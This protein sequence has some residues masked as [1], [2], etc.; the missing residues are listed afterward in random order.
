MAATLISPVRTDIFGTLSSIAG[1]QQKMITENQ[2]LKR[3]VVELEKALDVKRAK[4]SS[5]EA[6]IKSLM[7]RILSLSEKIQLKETENKMLRDRVQELTQNPKVTALEEENK[8]LRDAALDL[9]T[10]LEAE[11][12]ANLEY[13]E[14]QR[15]EV[16]LLQQEVANLKCRHR[17][18]VGVA[19]ALGALSTSIFERIVVGLAS[20]TL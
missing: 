18:Q 1:H 14:K 20:W 17:T 15:V 2:D 3:A 11:R 7:E 9:T 4:D 6:E 19:F 12:K 16:R 5:Q 8:H 13:V 10:Q